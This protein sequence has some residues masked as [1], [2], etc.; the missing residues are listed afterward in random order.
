MHH[1]LLCNSENEDCPN[2][3]AKLSKFQA[4]EFTFIPHANWLSEMERSL[5][6]SYEA[7][8]IF[9]F[10]QSRRQ[11]LANQTQNVCLNNEILVLPS[12]NV[13]PELEWNF[14]EITLRLLYPPHW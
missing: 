7:T 1:N 13:L 4:L 11:I 2:N 8:E 10:K 12:L 6:C 14:P 3:D 5:H 9:K